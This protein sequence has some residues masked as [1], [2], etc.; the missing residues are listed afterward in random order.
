V[1]DDPDGELLRLEIGAVAAGGSCVARHEGRVVFVRHTLP[2]ELVLARL[3]TPERA[4]DGRDLR[5]WRADAVRVLR[6][7]PERRPPACPA[8]GPGGCG[9]CDWQHA[10]LTAQRHGKGELV[11]EQLR[12]LAGLERSGLVVEPP[13]P[14]VDQAVDRAGERAGE[15]DADRQDDGLG[16]RTRVRFAVDD[17]GRAGMRA[18]RSHDVI[19]LTGCPIAHPD[20]AAVDVTGRA[21][22]GTAEVQVALG[23]APPA[24]VVVEPVDG[25]GKARG[26][27]GS[28]RVPPLPVEVSLA[29]RDPTGVTR[30]RG[31]SWVEHQVVLD[32]ETRSFRVSH[33]GFW[34][35]HPG[36]AQTLV[37]AVLDEAEPRPGERALDLY[38][39]AGLF[40]AALAARVGP[41]GAVLAIEGDRRAA[42]DARRNL[43][44]RPWVELACGRVETE[45]TRRL[46]GS[47][48]EG[49]AD[50][51]VLDPPRVGA[52]RAVMS[53][54]C[55]AGAR[56][57]LYVACDP[58]A[59]ARDV[60]VV[61]GPS[62]C[63]R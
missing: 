23:S 2:G 55:A 31:R 36:A 42:T 30:L 56:V 45:L 40:A 33:G 22:P 47:E 29:R 25:I 51:V 6:A 19:P 12:R 54:V 53:A 21:W 61:C 17:D 50:V 10:S 60:A 59:L 48:F 35:G 34:Q 39:G 32:G 26:V 41:D 57:V 28:L 13:G 44:D 16:W 4:D 46:P 15:Q 43:H 7:S 24:L 38:C 62:T 14:A 52:G 49:R 20:I 58:A 9:G 5:F 27:H 37:D 1:S 3:T 8:S 11:L 63:S 18:H